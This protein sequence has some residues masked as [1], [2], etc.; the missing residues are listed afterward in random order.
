MAVDEDGDPLFDFFLEEGE[1]PIGRLGY[2]VVSYF[3]LIYTMMCI[4]ALITIF[5]IPIMRNNMAWNGYDGDTQLSWTAQTTLGN[6]GE[7]TSRCT[8]LKMVS[9]KLAIGCQTGTI[10]EVTHYG[11]YAKESEADLKG[12]CAVD[13]DVSTGLTGCASVS[14]KEH[15]LYAD[16]LSTCIGK[17]SC[18]MNGVHDVLPLNTGECQLSVNSSLFIQYSCEIDEDE[19]EDKRYQALWAASTTVFS[20][21]VLLAVLRYRQGSISIEK[22]EWDIQ[23]VTASDYTIEMKIYP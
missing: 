22:R 15:P 14:S 17:Q 4:F 1:D 20:C 12:L 6:Y 13:P 7:A 19:L 2:G 9:E 11:V 3:S 21:L 18:V 10:T 23:T 8:T 16:K 5:F